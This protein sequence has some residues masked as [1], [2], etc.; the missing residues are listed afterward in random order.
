MEKRGISPLIAT[1][2][3]VGFTVALAAVIFTWGINFTKDTTE[4]TTQQAN[5]VQRCGEMSF[6]V[7]ASCADGKIDYVQV[8]N[9][10][11]INI[12]AFYL[13]ISNDQDTEGYDL[14]STDDMLKGFGVKKY[15]RDFSKISSPTKVEVIG[16]LKLDTDIVF[17]NEYVRESKVIC[18]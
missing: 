1:V 18:S 8:T 17:C 16:A 3:I 15:T 2:L 7:K 11:D 4:R 5:L 9:R 10:Q 6:D 14:N 13:R 12:Q